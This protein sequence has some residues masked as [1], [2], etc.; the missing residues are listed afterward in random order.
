MA[1]LALLIES[2]CLAT[3][4]GC[5]SPPQPAHV[6]MQ[7]RCAPL[8]QAL[9][10]AREQPRVAQYLV[11]EHMQPLT[12]QPSA[13]RIGDLV[14][15]SERGQIVTRHWSGGHDPLV[16][17]LELELTAGRAW[18]LPDGEVQ[19]DGQPLLRLRFRHPEVPAQY[20]PVTML[21]DPAS[22]LPVWHGYT[23][24]PGGFIWV[25]GDRGPGDGR[26]Q[27]QGL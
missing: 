15:E 25:Y 23:N 9:R 6:T 16:T 7:A 8:L 12:D 14:H 20:Q 26:K 13:F 24:L 11:D 22:G 10:L 18:C 1:R 2:C 27:R 19:R 21:I 3:L 4:V 17:R 5:T